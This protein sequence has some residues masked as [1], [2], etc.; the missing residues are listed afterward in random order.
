MSE[1]K[2]KPS[3]SSERSVLFETKNFEF[4]GI[5]WCAT[6]GD[7]F[8]DEAISVVVYSV[9]LSLFLSIRGGLII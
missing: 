6:R 5:P 7:Q 8:V 3:T 2:R 1:G 9:V 4:F